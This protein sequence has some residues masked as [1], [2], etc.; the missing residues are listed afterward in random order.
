MEPIHKFATVWGHTNTI[1]DM[2][3]TSF[4]VPLSLAFNSLYS[5]NFWT[6]LD[7]IGSELDLFS[8]ILAILNNT[9][10]ISANN[11]CSVVS[12]SFDY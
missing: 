4:I 7:I 11:N 9:K 10:N 3:Y 1:T 8:I 5:M 6:I 12:L 2:T